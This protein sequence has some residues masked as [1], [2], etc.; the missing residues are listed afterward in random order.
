[1]TCAARDSCRTTW[2]PEGRSRRMP[3]E[4][5]CRGA[6]LAAPTAC[7]AFRHAMR[8]TLPARRCLRQRALRPR[9]RTAFPRRS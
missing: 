8:C 6:C 2:P 5:C 7:R 4:T 1:M 9:N 3:W